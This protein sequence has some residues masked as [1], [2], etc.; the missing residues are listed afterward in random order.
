MTR[1]VATDS[2]PALPGAQIDLLY[3][4]L[5]LGSTAIWG[6]M[7]AWLLYFYLP[8]EGEGSAL[9]PAALYGG[10]M[11]AL[12]VLSAAITPTIGYLSDRTRTRLGRRL[13]YLLGSALPM[14]VFFVLLWTPPFRGTSPWNLVYLVAVLA[15]Y[16]LAYILNQVP[17]M[18]LLPEI[19]VTDAHRVRVSTWA[20]VMTVLGMMLAAGAGPLIERFGFAHTALIYA[21]VLLPAFY[22][23]LLVLRERPEH[24]ARPAVRLNFRQNLASMM[25]NRAFLFMTATGFC[26]WGIMGLVQASVPYIVTEICL[27]QESDTLMFYLPA[28]LASLLCYPLINWLAQRWGKWRV[29]AGSLLTSALVLPGLM[30]IGDW[31]PLS[32]KAQGMLWVTLQ[33]AALS[34]VVV[35]PRALGAEI[36]DHDEELTGQRR[37]GIYYATWGLLDQVVNGVMAALLPLLL[38]LGRSHLEPQGPLGVRL[39]GALGGAFMLAGFLIFLRYPLGRGRP[40]GKGQV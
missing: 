5:S 24:Q 21:V 36:V 14:L 32:L 29:F 10:A 25:R 34:G 4:L 20:A 38:L 31:L 15:G 28:V 3:G 7:S 19:A 39:V 33:A 30:L 12:R 23:P 16:N 13:P 9:V 11:L 6:V 17:T 26:F 18:A 1:T 8:P 22:L 40:A 35:L 37:E 27:L 2:R